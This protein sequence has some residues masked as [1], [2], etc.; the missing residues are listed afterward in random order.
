MRSQPVWWWQGLLLAMVIFGACLAWLHPRVAANAAEFYDT[1]WHLLTG[2]EIA[3]RGEVPRVDLFCFTSGAPGTSGTKEWFNLSWLAE[4]LAYRLYERW[5]FP[6]VLALSTCLYAVSLTLIGLTLRARRLSPF[7]FLSALLFVGY[8][9]FFNYDTRP[10]QFTFAL[11]SLTVYV[12][13]LPDSEARFT[14]GRAGLLLGVLG[15]WN[16]LHGGFVFGYCVVGVHALAACLSAWTRGEGLVAPRRAL[17]LGG[18]I[19]LGLASFVLHPHGLGALHHAVTYPAQFLP[20]LVVRV[21]ELAPP[22]FVGRDGRCREAYLLAALFALSLGRR[23]PGLAESLL[24][25]IFLHFALSMSRG[26]LPLVLVT[27]PW[28]AAGVDGALAR[29]RAARP[30]VEAAALV[31]DRRLKLAASAACWVVPGAAT[32]WLIFAVPGRAASEGPGRIGALSGAVSRTRHPVAAAQLIRSRQLEGRIFSRFE[33]GGLFEW[34]LYPDRRAFL[35][36]RGNVHAPEVYDDLFTIMD[37]R[38]GWLERLNAWQIDL[39]VMYASDTLPR[40]LADQLGWERLLEAD[41]FLVVRRPLRA[42]GP[43]RAAPPG[44]AHDPAGDDDLDRR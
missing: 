12:L 41:G 21:L 33:H 20:E 24:G 5:S 42:S 15:L 6:G 31:I 1:P 39:V 28:L 11:L 10:Q 23:P 27:V 22:T 14:W 3:S 26:F 9:L 35:D 4:L 43:A 8:V 30:L 19:G 38:R 40:V 2:Y 18:V 16:H 44:A 17:L 25:L 7:V 29:A 32:L 34:A 36:G 13:D 37:L